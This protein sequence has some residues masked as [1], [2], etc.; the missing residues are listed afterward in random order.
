MPLLLKH[1]FGHAPPLASRAEDPVGLSANLSA[2]HLLKALYTI[3]EAHLV[4]AFSSAMRKGKIGV[5]DFLSVIQAGKSCGD[6]A[7]HPFVETPAPCSAPADILTVPKE[8]WGG[9][10]AVTC[11][12]WQAK[13]DSTLD[14]ICAVGDP[15]L[16]KPAYMA[17]AVDC[18]HGRVCF[19]MRDANDASDASYAELCFS[20]CNHAGAEDSDGIDHRCWTTYTFAPGTADVPGTVSVK[21]QRADT[22]GHSPVRTVCK[23]EWHGDGAI[24][25][26]TGGNPLMHDQ[27]HQTKQLNYFRIHLQKQFN[28]WVERFRP[29][30]DAWIAKALDNAYEP[31]EGVGYKHAKRSFE[32]A[33][34]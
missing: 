6:A 17:G 24:V 30:L 18:K 10:T 29:K 32:S 28:G 14:L 22:T 7:I 20:A 11:Y 13:D 5:E 9:V 19:I 2:Q 4:K 12:N 3:D 21:E 1:P 23:A 8:L 15:G 27:F 16:S 33:C 31:K 25:V 34:A 26:T